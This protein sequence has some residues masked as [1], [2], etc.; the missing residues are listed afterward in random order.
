MHIHLDP[1]GGVSGDM[2]V[3][4][5]LDMSPALEPHLQRAISGLR[6]SSAVSLKRVDA[7]DG[8]LNGSGLSLEF[9]N[10]VG[11]DHAHNHL[12]DIRV[13]IGGSDLPK[14][15]RSRA[16]DIF[17]RLGRAEAQVHG[18]ALD[19]ITF[20]EVGALDSIVDIVSAA[21]LMETLGAE[22]WSVGPVPVGSGR[23][24]TQHGPLPV[25]A[26]ATL[27]LLRGMTVFD[28]GVPGERVTPTGAAIL[29]HLSPSQGFPA[30]PMRLTRSGCGFGERRFEALPN[31]LRVMELSR[32][33]RL[34]TDQA[35]LLGFEIDDQSPEDLAEGLE[36]LRAINGV[37]DVSTISVTGK[38]GRLG[39]GV[40]VICE[41]A[42]EGAALEAC[43]V[44][45]TTLGVRR[46][47]VERR[48]LPRRSTT[49]E[50]IGVKLA[51]RPDG[52]SA[53]AEMDHLAD[54]AEGHRARAVLGARLSEAAINEKAEI[55]EPNET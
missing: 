6:L 39:F 49:V 12:R 34:S 33:S 3:S 28:D 29:A 38:K 19:D 2:F 55:H 50:G 48:V 5:L 44:Q 25:P 54:A 47:I 37:H 42:A 23:V 24:C 4:A 35:L 11:G 1:V 14:P 32:E 21:V 8:T 30:T 15:V 9:E 13:L 16:L 22:S 51:E 45:T 20:H 40:R 18:T 53:K 27:L 17:E 52:V 31:I 7:G 26:P 36:R 10:E 41:P 43:F 46:Q